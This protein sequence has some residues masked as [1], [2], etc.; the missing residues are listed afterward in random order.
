MVGRRLLGS[1]WLYGDG[2]IICC[3]LD[4]R[5]RTLVL[6]VF[7]DLVD[8]RGSLVGIVYGRLAAVP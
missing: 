5:G 7:P 4:Q 6:L 3:L 8:R 1:Q 2:D